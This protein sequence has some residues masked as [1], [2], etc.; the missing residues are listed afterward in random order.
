MNLKTHA[1]VFQISVYS[2]QSGVVVLLIDPNIYTKIVSALNYYRDKM[3][4]IEGKIIY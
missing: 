3:F 1:N 4:I 2:V